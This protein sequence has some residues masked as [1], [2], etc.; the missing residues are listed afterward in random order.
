M[1][2]WNELRVGAV[3]GPISCLLY[4]FLKLRQ[5]FFKN[6]EVSPNDSLNSD[7]FSCLGFF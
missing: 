6:I 7:S 3:R 1:G 2:V 4:R 5:R